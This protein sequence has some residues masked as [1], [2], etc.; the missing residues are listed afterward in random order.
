MIRSSGFHAFAFAVVMVCGSVT[1]AQSAA[2]V[3]QPETKVEPKEEPK[4][5]LKVYDES[6]DAKKQI[7]AALAKAKKNNRR[8]LIQ[9]GANW[10]GWCIKLHGTFGSNRE[11]A[12]QLMYEYDVV[13]VDVGQF[14]KHMEIAEGY[15]ADLKKHGLPFLTVLDADGKAI[16]NQETGSLEKKAESGKDNPMEHEPKLVLEFLK[17]HQAAYPEA[18]AVFD[19][20]MA[21]AKKSGKQVFVHFGAP[22]CGWCHKLEDWMAQPE[23]AKILEKE[24]VDCKIDVDRTKNPAAIQKRLGKNEKGGIPWFCFVAADGTKTADSDGEKGNV[25][26][27]AAPEEIEHFKGMLTKTTKLSAAEVEAVVKSLEAKK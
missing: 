20:A 8:V 19:A 2:P 13:Y 5:K 17:K 11:I 3:A 23:I 14:N 25:G 18:N 1:S 27:P 15:G 21:E 7:D 12:K 22:W 9:W 4:A 26:F 6:A 24:F 10:C 16:A